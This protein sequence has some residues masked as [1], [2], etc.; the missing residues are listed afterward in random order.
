MHD[1]K[2]TA[3]QVLGEL[4]PAATN[5]RKRILLV[6]DGMDSQI[7]MLMLLGEAEADVVVAENGQIAVDLATTQP[8]DLILMDMQMPVMDG[9]AAASE[10][11]R[12]GLSTPIIALTANATMG[13][14]DRCIASGCSGY[15]SKPIDGETLLHT[16][17]QNLRDH[18]S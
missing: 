14:R 11:R 6:E 18:S 16:V 17:N 1:L 15:L 13:D 2:E 8:F 5:V 7:L 10:L 3:P 12:L 4:P 9:Y